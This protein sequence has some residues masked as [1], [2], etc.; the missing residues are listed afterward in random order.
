[1]TPHD[2]F[3]GPAGDLSELARAA[4]GAH[5]DSIPR[6]ARHLLNLA[7]SSPAA[8]LTAAA[9]ASG[10]ET[11]GV[12]YYAAALAELDAAAA[13]RA[14][15]LVAACLRHVAGAATPTAAHLRQA[16]ALM[17]DATPPRPG[18]RAIAGMQPLF[19]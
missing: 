8:G 15:G 1:V 16:A 17:R 5:P 7:A 4:R 19:T 10:P 18:L 11:A 14:P 6:A 9:D 3:T 13:G 2:P 12:L